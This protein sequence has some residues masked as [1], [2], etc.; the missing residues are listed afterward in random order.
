[1]VRPNPITPGARRAA[2]VPRPASQTTR[3]QRNNATLSNARDRSIGSIPHHRVAHRV[4]RR[5]ATGEVLVVA[6]HDH[7]IVLLFPVSVVIGSL[8]LVYAI[9][10]LANYATPVVSVLGLVWIGVVIWACLK[11]WEHE[12]QWFVLTDKRV[13][14]IDGIIETVAMLP[15][16]RLTDILFKRSLWGQIFGYGKFELESAGQI[17]ALRV[18]NY[19]ARPNRTHEKLTEL[20]YKSQ[21]EEPPEN[22]GA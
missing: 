6:Q 11:W 19:V 15:L 10:S 13:M 12:V 17:Q 22:D 8:F 18:I 14:K 20:L 21:E 7:A 5:L 9:S 2:S 16:P 3:T 1:V 4:R